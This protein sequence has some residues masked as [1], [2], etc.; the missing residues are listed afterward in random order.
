LEASDISGSDDESAQSFFIMNGTSAHFCGEQRVDDSLDL[1]TG[2]L[3]DPQLTCNIACNPELIIPGS[4]RKSLSNLQLA[5]N[6]G[7]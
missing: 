5:T 7:I 3:S 6:A 4:L 1:R 2:W